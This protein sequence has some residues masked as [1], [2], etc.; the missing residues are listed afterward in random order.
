MATASQGRDR[1]HTVTAANVGLLIFAGSAKLPAKAR[2]FDGS[3]VFTV[4]VGVRPE[5]MRV[6]EAAT[7]CAPSLGAKLL[8]DSLVGK[9]LGPALREAQEQ[10]RARYF[11]VTQRAMVAAL[12]DLARRH[13]EFCDAEA[14]R[15]KRTEAGQQA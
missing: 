6:V 12:E 9:P 8:T 13:Q 3:R 5:D 10:L 1:E 14:E 7:N 2:S 11:N 15:G 4:E